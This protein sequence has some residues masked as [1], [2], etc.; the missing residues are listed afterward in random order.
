[1]SIDNEFAVAEADRPAD[2][3]IV[4]PS[5][6][7]SSGWPIKRRGAV[8]NPKVH[9]YKG[10]EFIAKYFSQFTFCSHCN[11]FLW[12]VTGKQGYQCRS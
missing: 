10:H 6:L 5:H 8:K 3:D 9:E 4:E 2:G 1:M 11:Q 7:P 12:G